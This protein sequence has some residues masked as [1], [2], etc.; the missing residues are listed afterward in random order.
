LHLA[1]AAHIDGKIEL[2]IRDR[3]RKAG[4]ESTANRHFG[5][6]VAASEVRKHGRQ[7]GAAI[8]IRNADDDGAFNGLR[9]EFPRNPVKHREDLAG[10]AQKL[11]ARR[12][13]GNAARLAREERHTKSRLETLDLYAHSRLGAM[14]FQGGAC[15]A[16]VAH[17]EHEAAQQLDVEAGQAIV[18]VHG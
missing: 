4:T 14:Q 6:G 5:T 16:A 13:Q 12:C 1:G 11:L 10:L 9:A 7:Y 8:L 3:V 17:H 18:M 2:V 15:N